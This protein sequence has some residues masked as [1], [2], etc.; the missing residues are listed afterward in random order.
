[1]NILTMLDLTKSYGSSRTFWSI[2]FMRYAGLHIGRYFTMLDV[3]SM[4]CH[5]NGLQASTRL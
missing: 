4:S 5:A 1:M 2:S 3:L